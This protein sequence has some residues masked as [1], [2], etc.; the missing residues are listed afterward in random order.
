MIFKDFPKGW[1]VKLIASVAGVSALNVPAYD[2]NT[3]A[4]GDSG[5]AFCAFSGSW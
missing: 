4:I 2:G 3:A 1:V 5:F